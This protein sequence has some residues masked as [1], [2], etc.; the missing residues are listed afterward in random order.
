MCIQSS[1]HWGCRMSPPQSAQ[2]SWAAKV[3]RCREESRASKA[4][5]KGEV[6]GIEVR[7]VDGVSDSSSES[8]LASESAEERR[9]LIGGSLGVP[10][11]T[12]GTIGGG[13]GLNTARLVAKT[14]FAGG[15]RMRGLTGSLLTTSS[16]SSSLV[17]ADS[18][19]KKGRGTVLR[20]I[21]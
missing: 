14:A 12:T 4:A 21:E 16:P 3:S 7:I 11:F 18:S 6:A 8:R 17:G 5:C 15:L 1:M 10:D 19:T 13:A 20:L 9:C 2:V